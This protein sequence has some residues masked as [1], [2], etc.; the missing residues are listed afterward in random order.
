MYGFRELTSKF[1]FECDRRFGV[2]VVVPSD[3][4]SLS[5][6]VC[7]L[8]FAYVAIEYSVYWYWRNW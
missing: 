1:L 8:I 2:N 4:H 7:W 3:C 6:N 5:L